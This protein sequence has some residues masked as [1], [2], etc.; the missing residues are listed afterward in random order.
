VPTLQALSIY[1]SP[2]KCTKTGLKTAL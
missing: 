1:F 2:N